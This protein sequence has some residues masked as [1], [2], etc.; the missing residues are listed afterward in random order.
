L[1]WGKGCLWM[2]KEPAAINPED[3]GKKKRRI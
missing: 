3:M 2:G 1:G